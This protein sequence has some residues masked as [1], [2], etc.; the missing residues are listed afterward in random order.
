[1]FTWSKPSDG[2]MQ[3]LADHLR[4]ESLTYDSP[5]G[6]PPPGFVDDRLRVIL[7][8]G[9]ATFD[10]ARRAIQ[11]WKM[12]PPVL[13]ELWPSR[14]SI[15]PGEIVQV[16]FRAGPLWTTNPCRILRV[17]DEAGDKPR[18]GFVYGTLPGHVERGE[19][20]FLVEWDRATD[21]VTYSLRAFSQPAH[22][23][24]WLGYPYTRLQQARFRRLSGQAMQAA[25]QAEANS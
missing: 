10:A 16:L 2:V 15:Q 21:V 9:P 18:F 4:S 5:D 22:W 8:A 25:V 13:S 7:G 14:P 12:F 6:C 11:N 1:V 3:V 17:I 19:E 24:V 20:T 23:L